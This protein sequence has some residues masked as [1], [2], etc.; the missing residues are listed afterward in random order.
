MLGIGLPELILLVVVALVVF[1][2]EKLPELA[3]SLARMIVSFREATRE[4]RSSLDEEMRRFKEDVKLTEKK[5]RDGEK[6]EK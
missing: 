3:K 5:S 4:V 6:G 1:D 2:P